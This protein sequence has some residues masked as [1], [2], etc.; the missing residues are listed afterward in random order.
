MDV[1]AAQVPAFEAD[2]P[3]IVQ[4]APAQVPIKQEPELQLVQRHIIEEEQPGPPPLNAA[5]ALRFKTYLALAVM[6]GILLVGAPISVITAYRYL[7]PVYMYDQA[8]NP[9]QQPAADP[10][11]A[12]AKRSGSGKSGAQGRG[13]A[14]SGTQPRS[15]RSGRKGQAPSK[16][17]VVVW[18]KPPQ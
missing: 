18:P 6:A 16:Q 2:E 11:P 10:N 1:V 13:G 4:T 8:P 15:A 3:E 12:S 14:N 7:H 5:D 17:P 9:V